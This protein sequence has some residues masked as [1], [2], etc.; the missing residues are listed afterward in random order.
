MRSTLPRVGLYMDQG[1][2]PGSG[3]A[4]L[5][6]LGQRKEMRPYAVDGSFVSRKMCLGGSRRASREVIYV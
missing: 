3:L 4:A 6:T 1:L 5:G 2:N